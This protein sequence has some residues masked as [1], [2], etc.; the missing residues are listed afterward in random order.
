VG[1]LSAF[2]NVPGVFG[3]VT[4]QSNNF[5]G[6]DCA[7]VLVAAFGQWKK[8]PIK[9]NYN[10]SMLAASM[11]KRGESELSG[12]VPTAKLKWGDDI[13]PGDLIA[14]K[15]SGANRYQHIGALVGDT[16]KDGVLSSGDIVWHAGPHPVR[17]APL[18]S[19][20]FDGH[21]VI[22]RPKSL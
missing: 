6:V 10:V 8:R 15:Y 5:I 16:D 13:A 17:S 22:L 14:V 11:P 2:F 19:G 20:S 12:G 9:K 7:D 21:V 1:A 4:Y 18:S 3:S